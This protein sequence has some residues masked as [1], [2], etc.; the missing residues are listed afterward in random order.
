MKITQRIILI[1]ALCCTTSCAV[2]PSSTSYIDLLKHDIQEAM[3]KLSTNY[4][5]PGI[6]YHYEDNVASIDLIDLDT[7]QIYTLEYRSR[8]IRVLKTENISDQ[9]I[10]NKL[11]C[12]ATVGSLIIDPR[13]AIQIVNK[14]KN[15]NDD[16][17]M[18]AP[19]LQKGVCEAS[20]FVIGPGNFY[21]VDSATGAI[22][23]GRTTK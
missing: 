6:I 18:F 7:K 15:V 1:I 13:R 12:Q 14:Q 2:S 22:L 5:I 19:S 11:D 3:P 23:D 17:A 20:W 9:T 10:V 16:M 21:F 4:A 8:Q